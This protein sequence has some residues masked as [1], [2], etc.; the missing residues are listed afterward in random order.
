MRVQNF[1]QAVKLFDWLDKITLT[2]SGEKLIDSIVNSSYSLLIHH[3]RSAYISAGVTGA[4]ISDNL[5]N[6]VG[7]S[8]YI[9]FFLDMDDRGSHCV[10]AMNGRDY[11]EYT[12]LQ[13]LYHEL[14]HAKHKMRGSWL[15]FDSEGQAIREENVFRQEWAKYRF[16][17]APVLRYDESD[18]NPLILNQNGRCIPLT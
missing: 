12:A 2:E 15:Y 4:D 11:I 1:G 14:V 7:A 9:K 16:Q 10:L 17:K 18:D 3:S 6:G 13:N 8:A 5:I